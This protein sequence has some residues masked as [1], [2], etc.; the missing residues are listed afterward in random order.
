MLNPGSLYG[1]ARPENFPLV[2][3]Y[4]NGVVAEALKVMGFVNRF[5][6]GEDCSSSGRN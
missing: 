4:R 3:D 5:S 2:N 1:K 6:C